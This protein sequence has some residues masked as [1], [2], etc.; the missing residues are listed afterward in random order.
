MWYDRSYYRLLRVI[1]HHALAVDWCDFWWPWMV[2]EVH[3]TLTLPLPQK[4]YRIRPQKL[5]LKLLIWNQTSAFRWYECRWPWRYFKV[6]RL[7]HSKFLA[8]AALYGKTYYRV[9]WGNHAVAVD[10][11]HFWQLWNTFEGR[12][13]P[14]CH[15]HVHF[16]NRW[17]AFV[18]W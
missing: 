14:S 18:S 2:F 4:L 15:F 13:S 8:N 5:K 3:F 7:F 12:F 16:S 11:C 17:Q 6:I 1:G 10:W 9:R